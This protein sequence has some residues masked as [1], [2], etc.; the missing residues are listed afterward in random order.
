MLTNDILERL[1]IDPGRRTLGELLQ[2]REAAAHEIARLRSHIE[3]LQV[4]SA[5]A[6]PE[7]AAMP[8]SL[9]PREATEKEP[10]FRAGSLI[11]L[12][13]VRELL[14]VSASTVYRWQSEGSFPKPLKLGRNMVRWRIDDIVAWRDAVSR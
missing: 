3:R 8:P 10:P 14:G 6:M 7:R 4:V 11:R 2:D 12:A 13:D 9:A 5:R 1:R